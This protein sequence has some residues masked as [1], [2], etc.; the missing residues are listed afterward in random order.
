MEA[1]RAKEI[2]ESKDTYAVKLE[3]DSVWIENVDVARGT[4][5]VTVGHNQSDVQTVDCG[6]LEEV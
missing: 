1:A 3:G 2:L 6:R 4:A 5:T